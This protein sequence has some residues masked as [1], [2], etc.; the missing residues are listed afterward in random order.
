MESYIS[1][2]ISKHGEVFWLAPGVAQASC[3]ISHTYMAQRKITRTRMR[4]KR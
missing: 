4:L 3:N 1:Y 2:A